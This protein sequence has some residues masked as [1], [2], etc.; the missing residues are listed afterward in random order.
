MSLAVVVAQRLN[1]SLPL[2]E[3]PPCIHQEN[4]T[5]QM[6]KLSGLEAL[7]LTE[8]SNFVNIGER[9]NVTGSRAFLRMI[10]DGDFEA[11][12]AVAREQVDGGA[13]VLD[14]NM[15]EG[16]IDGKAAMVRFLNLL[17]AE[18]DIA[19]IPIMI[20]SSKLEI[21]HAGLKCLQ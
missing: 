21:I 1:T 14:I 7:V 20:D 11:A 2:P 17:A 13:Q 12:L 3:L 8:Q 19:R 16:M 5:L 9:T 6:L 10:K 15:D 4:G 18:P